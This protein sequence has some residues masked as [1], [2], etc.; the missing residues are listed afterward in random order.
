MDPISPHKPIAR[1]IFYLLGSLLAQAKSLWPHLAT[2]TAK[3]RCD[4][5]IYKHFG[6][7][8]MVTVFS[9]FTPFWHFYIL[10]VPSVSSILIIPHSDRL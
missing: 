7:S 5:N 1:K 6:T 8:I 3:K 10:K 4:G 9:N 2:Q